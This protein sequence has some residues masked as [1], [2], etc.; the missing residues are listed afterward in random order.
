MS[1]SRRRLESRVA[2]GGE[3][4]V[5][6]AQDAQLPEQFVAAGIDPV[7]LAAPGAAEV[8]EHEGVAAVGLGLTRVEVGGRGASPARA[9]TPP[10]RRGEPRR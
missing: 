1:A 9:R 7:E 6:A 3:V 2:V 5:V 10:A 8:G 4:G